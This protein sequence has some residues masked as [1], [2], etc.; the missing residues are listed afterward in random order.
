MF[1][2]TPSE[3]GV[4]QNLCFWCSTT[5]C[6][7]LSHSAVVITCESARLCR[8]REKGGDESD[9]PPKAGGHV[10]PIAALCSTPLSR[11]PWGRSRPHLSLR[12]GSE[13]PPGAAPKARRRT[14]GMA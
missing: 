3:G 1:N 9:P 2:G 10:T 6:H 7:Y 8:T 12:E 4:F 11:P 14:Y 13:Q 5:V